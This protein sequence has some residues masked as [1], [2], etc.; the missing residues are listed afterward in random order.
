MAILFTPTMPDWI[1]SPIADALGVFCDAREKFAVGLLLHVEA[2]RRNTDLPGVTIFE[3]RDSISGLF[4][5]SVGEYDDRRMAA[6]LHRRLL[7]S[8]RSQGSEMFAD[9]N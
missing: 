2:R 6:E 5:V 4:R 3:R 9:R 7:H 1:E 8:L